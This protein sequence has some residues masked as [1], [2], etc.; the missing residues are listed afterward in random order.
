MTEI[1][2]LPSAINISKESAPHNIEAEQALLGA[3]LVNN[4]VYD[5][6]ANI[7][8]ETHFLIQC[9]EKFLK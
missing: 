3:L 1:S 5:R 6:I 4:D 9:M 8:N 2:T 7:V